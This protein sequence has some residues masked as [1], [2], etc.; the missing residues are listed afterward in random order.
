M[1]IAPYQWVESITYTKTD[2][3]QEGLEG[4]Y[5]PFIVNRGLS[6]NLDCILFASEMNR[7]S[8]LTPRM[9]Y[10]FL[11][12]SIRKAKRYG[13]WIKKG[14][15]DKKFEAR[16]DII[17][18]YYSVS[19]DR[20]EDYLSLLTDDQYKRIEKLMGGDVYK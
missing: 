17:Q 10:D 11:S 19:R 15:I 18:K 1:T 4:E 6:N 5:I 7:L 12:F 8:N 9:Q 20:A 2:L 3:M 14:D 13:K 16:L